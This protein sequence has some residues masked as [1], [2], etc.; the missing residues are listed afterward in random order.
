MN[1]HF[2]IEDV[3]QR[4]RVFLTGPCPA[5]EKARQIPAKE[6]VNVDQPNIVSADS[7]SKHRINECAKAEMSGLTPFPY[8]HFWIPSKV[9]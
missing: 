6:E 3:P 1:I 8:Q 5:V 7:H 2:D 4:N 9:S